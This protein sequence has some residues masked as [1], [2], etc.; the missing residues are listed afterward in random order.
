MMNSA[1]RD[2]ITV[3]WTG[4]TKYS[5]TRDQFTVLW[6]GDTKYSATRDLNIVSRTNRNRKNSASRD[7][8]TVLCT[9]D[10]KYYYRLAT[11]SI[12]DCGKRRKCC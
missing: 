4:D 10:T 1:S 5:A 9:S 12:Q 8:I 7:Q 11:Q 3:L 2:Q 6:T